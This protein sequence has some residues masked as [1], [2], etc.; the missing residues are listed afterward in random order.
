[1]LLRDLV[2]RFEADRKALA[3]TRCVFEDPKLVKRL[4]A[5]AKRLDRVMLKDTRTGTRPATPDDSTSYRE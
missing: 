3:S 1:M 5:T 2:L 4:W